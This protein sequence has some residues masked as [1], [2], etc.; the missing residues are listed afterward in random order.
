MHKLSHKKISALAHEFLTTHGA[1]TALPV[2]QQK[3]IEKDLELTISKAVELE[4]EEK[5][6]RSTSSYLSE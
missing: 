6:F 2:Y 4:N 3:L 5:V 1:L